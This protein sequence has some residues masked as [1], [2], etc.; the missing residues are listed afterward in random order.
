MENSEVI[1][2]VHDI[3]E[4]VC[5]VDDDIERGDFFT[6]GNKYDIIQILGLVS[7]KFNIKIPDKEEKIIRNSDDLFS[8]IKKHISNK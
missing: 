6:F 5:G 2:K 7:E 3:V 8:V 4:S 1:E